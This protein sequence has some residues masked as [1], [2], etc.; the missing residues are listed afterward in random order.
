MIV[1]TTNTIQDKEIIEYID[2]VNGEAIM[3]ANIVRDIFASVRDVVGGR[4]GAYE[5]KLKE[6]RDIAM[7]EMKQLATQKGANA[8]VGI[9]V[10]YEVIRDG[11]LMVAISGTAV[12]V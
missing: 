8:I 9:D 12:R 11:M 1:T 6:A 5:S 7:E 4:S 3:G 10:D 2:I